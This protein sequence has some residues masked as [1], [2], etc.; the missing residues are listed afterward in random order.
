MKK[1]ALILITAIAFCACDNEEKENE[2]FVLQDPPDMVLDAIV[3]DSGLL[4][5]AQDLEDSGVDELGPDAIIYS[6]C[7]DG[8]DNDGDGQTDYP[9]DD[10]CSTAADDDE[11][12]PNFPACDDGIDNDNDGLVDFEDPGCSSFTD[13]DENNICAPGLSFRDISS[14]PTLESVTMGVSKLNN[15]RNN[16]APELLF[17]FTLRS[18]IAALS[19]ETTGSSFDTILGVYGSCPGDEPPELCGDDQSATDRTSKVFIE[20]PELGDYYLVV[21]GHN[22][23]SGQVILAV[24]QYVEDGELCDDLPEGTT[25]RIGRQCTAGICVPN[26]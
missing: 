25:C 12:D 15:C 14:T 11:T 1:H 16:Q 17:L 19:F 21:D 24:N 18:P 6:A 13:P 10:G 2:L 8:V 7:E 9:I 3:I 20:A 23:A 5:D 22:T 4:A 26:A